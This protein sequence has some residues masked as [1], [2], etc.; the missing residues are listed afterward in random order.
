MARR[1]KRPRGQRVW[2]PELDGKLYLDF[3][4]SSNIVST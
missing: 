4:N 3:M 1:T 2:D